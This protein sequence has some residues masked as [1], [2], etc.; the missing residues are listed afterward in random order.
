M[1][2]D[3]NV[4]TARGPRYA[5]PYGVEIVRYLLG[6]DVANE[7]GTH[8][9]LLHSSNTKYGKSKICTPAPQVLHIGGVCGS[10]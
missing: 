3:G 7:G 9:L 5:F 1:V 2:T 8:G 4:I 6:N 10:L